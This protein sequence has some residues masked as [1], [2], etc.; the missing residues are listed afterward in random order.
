MRRKEFLIPFFHS[1]TL[2]I[3]QVIVNCKQSGTRPFHT[4]FEILGEAQNIVTGELD[5]SQFEIS[6]NE[7]YTCHHIEEILVKEEI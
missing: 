6:K 2:S 4:E 3:F 7:Y 1:E 5:A